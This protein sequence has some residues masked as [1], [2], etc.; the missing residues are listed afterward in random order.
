MGPKAPVAPVGPRG[1]FRGPKRVAPGTLWA[2]F[3]PPF[4]G[5]F[6]LYFSY[7]FGSDVLMISGGFW[8]PFWA[9]FW[10]RLGVILQSK[11]HTKSYWNFDAVPKWIWG[12]PGPSEL[13]NYGFSLS[14]T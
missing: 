13:E 7:F 1:R 10:L 6:G 11:I 9:P 2:P 8:S 12:A 3:W 5:H 14:K 4:W